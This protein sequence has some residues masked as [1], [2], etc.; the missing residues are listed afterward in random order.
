LAPFPIA[1]SVVAVFV[2]AQHG[3]AG[4]V[5]TLR[6]VPRGLLGFSV[7]CFLVSVLVGPAG[8]PTAF[9]VA[10]AGTL[11]VQL[12]SRMVQA[13]SVRI[14]VL[15]LMPPRHSR[16]VNGGRTDIERVRRMRDRS[17][18][19]TQ[20]WEIVPVGKSRTSPAI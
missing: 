9:G 20:E 10:L 19:R 2:L 17:R 15:R 13:P 6:G 1:T 7:F 12:L 18:P 5:R 3:S 8:V 11:A 4:A 14:A 16:A